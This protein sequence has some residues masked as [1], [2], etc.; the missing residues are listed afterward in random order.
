MDQRAIY[1]LSWKEKKKNH[2]G[3]L[4]HVLKQISEQL[5]KRVYFYFDH[6]M[7]LETALFWLHYLMLSLVDAKPHFSIK[8]QAIFFFYSKHL[9]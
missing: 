9:F 1:H 3:L 5:F 7:R 6:R 4:A 8:I 2:I